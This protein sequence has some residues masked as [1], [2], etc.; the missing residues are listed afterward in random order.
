MS[1]LS[2][3]A[4]ELRYRRFRTIGIVMIL[5]GVLLTAA[6][7]FAGAAWVGLVFVVIG[8]GLVVSARAQLARSRYEPFDY[9]GELD[10]VGESFHTRDLHDIYM[11]AGQDSNRLLTAVLLPEPNNPHDPNAIAVGIA[12]GERRRLVGHLPRAIA[13][14]VAP[15]LAPYIARGVIPSVSAIID[16]P[17]TGDRGDT[18]YKVRIFRTPT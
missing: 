1:V 16:E 10:V 2:N 18:I 12:I 6:L 15:R 14:E 13:A 5:F 3:D 11:A 4:A 8:I 17:F 7:A 9:D